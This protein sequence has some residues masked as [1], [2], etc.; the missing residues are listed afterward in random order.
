MTAV[1]KLLYRSGRSMRQLWK[2]IEYWLMT[3]LD[4]KFHV[5]VYKMTCDAVQ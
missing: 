5:L 3:L 1:R 2:A 4:F